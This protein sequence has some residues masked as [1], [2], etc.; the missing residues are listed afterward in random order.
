MLLP[1]MLALPIW[2]PAAS[3]SVAVPASSFGMAPKCVFPVLRNETFTGS[4]WPGSDLPMSM[5][6]IS[7]VLVWGVSAMW[8]IALTPS[9]TP[10][11]TL[12]LPL[13]EGGIPVTVRI[14]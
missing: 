3:C 13:G 11:P 5:P 7:P 9:S 1:L 14:A 2:A 4:A 8:T 10:K 12:E 6:L